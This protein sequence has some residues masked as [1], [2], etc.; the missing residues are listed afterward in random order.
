[1][2]EVTL[3]VLIILIAD[4]LLWNKKIRLNSNGAYYE[5]SIM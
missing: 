1:M 4:T 5:L 2:V 3:S